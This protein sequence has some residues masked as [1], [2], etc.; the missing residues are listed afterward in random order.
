M[1]QKLLKFTKYISV[2]ILLIISIFGLWW[3][4][5][6]PS[7]HRD[8]VADQEILPYATFSTQDLVTIHNISNNTYRSTTDFD[9]HYYDKT[10][11]LNDIKKVWFLVEP[12]AG[13]KGAAHTLLSFEFTDNQFISISVEIRKEKGESFSAVQGLLNQYELMYVIGDEQDVVKLR[14]NYRK[15]EVFLYPMKATQVQT[16]QLFV[17]MLNR[18]NK[19]TITP[20]FYNT[21]VNTC[22]TNIVAHVNTISP[23]RIPLRSE[24]LFPAYSDKLAYDVGLIDTTLS[25]EEARKHFKINDQAQEFANDPEFSIRIRE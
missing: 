20:E 19:L 13:F 5:H 10:F 2:L 15:D 25:F 12:F 8:W 18:T 16:R 9:I 23:S 7:L 6:I 14:S 21:L 3:I 17:D 1:K 24:I 11:N 4:S 22:T